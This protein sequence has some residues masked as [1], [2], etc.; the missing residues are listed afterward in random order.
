VRFIQREI[1]FKIFTFVSISFFVIFSINIY[2]NTQ[3]EQEKISIITKIFNE[4]L[5]TF[6]DNLAMINED[7]N[8]ILNDYFNMLRTEDELKTPPKTF[9]NYIYSINYYKTTKKGYIIDSNIED[10]KGNYYKNNFIFN[11]GDL[12]FDESLISDFVLDFKNNNL[13]KFFITKNENYFIILEL[14][15]SENFINNIFQRI[16]TSLISDSA[17]IKFSNLYIIDSDKNI[18]MIQSD[19]N[20]NNEPTDFIS[21]IIDDIFHT[22]DDHITYNNFYNRKLYYIYKLKDTGFK[23]I[24]Y[25]LEISVDNIY[26][27][28]N[29]LFSIVFFIVFMIVFF[30]FIKAINKKSKILLVSPLE[31]I[32]S[33]YNQFDINNP[34]KSALLSIKDMYK[35][36]EINILKN[37]T[38]NFQISLKNYF[39]DLKESY[40]ELENAYGTIEEKNQELRKAYLNFAHKLSIIAEGHDENTGQHV[41]RVGEISALIADKLG[42]DKGFVEDIKKF[43]PL[44]D[45]GKIFVPTEII[46]KKGSLTENEWKIMKNHTISAKELLDE[47]FF[48]MAQN[49]ALYHHEKWDGSGYPYGIKGDNIPLEAQIVQLADIFDALRSPRS[50]KKGFSLQETYKI[51]VKG[52]DRVKPEHFNPIILEV[53]KENYEEID[54]IFKKLS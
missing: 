46:N 39:K 16:S 19:N 21:T 54:Y 17:D 18:K 26:T 33:N 43:A 7:F 40:D 32:I 47:E 30:G 41:Y 24:R 9:K 31:K 8:N 20:L 11:S 37:K 50:Y 5:H 44:H 36:E 53:F 25:V 38:L 1:I 23:P 6:E 13:K 35:I 4:T 22:K 14:I 42:M 28:K 15:I 51:I 49:I 29:I 2:E 3:Q 10:L 12:F 45:I 34:E 27:L 48:H 52:D